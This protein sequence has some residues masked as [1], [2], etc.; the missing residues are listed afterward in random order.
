MN[1]IVCI[2]PKDKSTAFLNVLVKRL[3]KAFPKQFYCLKVKATIDDHQKCLELIAALPPQ[4]LILYLGHG[5]SDKLLGANDENAAVEF[6]NFRKKGFINKTNID[7]LSNKKVICISCRSNEK[8]GKMAEKTNCQT[9]VGFG[10]I[11][12][13]WIIEADEVNIQPNDVDWFN[14]LFCKVMSDALIYAIH[15]QFNFDQFERV[16]KLMTNHMIIRQLHPKKEVAN[17]WWVDESLY[18]LKDEV[19]IFGNRETL[20]LEI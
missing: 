19:K 5:E 10:S 3:E 17:A 8:L 14:K 15:H 16:L 4:N 13:D 2:F 12:T 18:K 7:I 6:K 20:L 9:F 1:K 11:P